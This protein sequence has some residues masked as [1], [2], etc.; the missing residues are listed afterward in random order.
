M[1]T[2]EDLIAALFSAFAGFTAFGVAVGGFLAA[3]GGIQ[4]AV[5]DWTQHG[6]DEVEAKK[7]AGKLTSERQ[8]RRATWLA[9]HRV[10]ALWLM[11]VFIF[12]VVLVSGFGLFISF[13][14]LYTGAG[15]SYRG[16]IYLFEA[17]TIAL[18]VVTLSAVAIAA[19]GSASGRSGNNEKQ[20]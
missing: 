13:W 3:G 4:H 6:L 15:W 8:I 1:V 16:A 11:A 17:E 20:N 2:H 19:S 18:T 10:V 7:A 9:N 5:F 12:L 14:W